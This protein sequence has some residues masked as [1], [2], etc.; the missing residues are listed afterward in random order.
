MIC[1]ASLV[2]ACQDAEHHL[3]RM[4]WQSGEFRNDVLEHPGVAKRISAPYLSAI[5][6][7]GLLLN[8]VAGGGGPIQ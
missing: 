4:R 1:A 8:A 5:L 2:A 6:L 3:K 7:G